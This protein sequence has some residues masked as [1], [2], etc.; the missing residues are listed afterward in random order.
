V[1]ARVGERLSNA[2]AQ[3]EVARVAF[4][5]KLAAHLDRRC[6]LLSELGVDA[7]EYGV[8]AGVEG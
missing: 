8:S 3:H 7:S 1:V 6:A 4:E 5:D 2:G